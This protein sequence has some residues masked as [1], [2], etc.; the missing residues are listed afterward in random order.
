[1]DLIALIQALS[2]PAAY[3]HPVS[4]VEVRH[5]HVS[6]VFLAGNNAY[7]IK[8]PVEL[9]FLDFRTLEKRRHFCT[10]E[11][12]LNRRLAPST[13]L[14]VVPVARNGPKVEMEAQ[15][16]VVEWAVKMERLP[17]SA[18]LQSRLARGE[19]DPK[20]VEALGRKVACFHA[21]AAAGEHVSLYG[22]FDSVAR[23]RVGRDRPQAD[24]PPI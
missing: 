10:E 19:V 24:R 13:Y 6:V 17:E 5:T 2:E 3:S 22:R 18:T 21:R 1:M 14:G 11:V 20:V 8:K 16:K 12:R 7:K 9:G 15:G 23:S 4:S